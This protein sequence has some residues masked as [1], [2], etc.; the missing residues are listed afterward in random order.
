[1]H[2]QRGR[3]EAGD[4]FYV[5][6]WAKRLI[7]IPIFK[8]KK[9]RLFTFDFIALNQNQISS[10]S[11]C[12]KELTIC[13]WELQN[14]ASRHPTAQSLQTHSF[15]LHELQREEYPRQPALAT[16]PCPWLGHQL[17]THF[18]EGTEFTG[19]KTS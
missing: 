12:L 15:S 11:V 18:T 2:S 4:S 3:E 13:S 8:H 7:T 1:M 5:G 14:A 6:N 17:L 19:S 10:F 9:K 16:D